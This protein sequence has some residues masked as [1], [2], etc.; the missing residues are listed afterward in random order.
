MRG[1][2][3]EKEVEMCA[4]NITNKTNAHTSLWTSPMTNVVA[5]TFSLLC[6]CSYELN[7]ETTAD[8]IMLGAFISEGPGCILGHVMSDLRWT[9]WRWDRFSPS[10]SVSPTN[11]HY[12]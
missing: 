5:L 9:N 11:C 1:T 2:G 7:I 8:T 3:I 4:T 12:T 10:T 6:R